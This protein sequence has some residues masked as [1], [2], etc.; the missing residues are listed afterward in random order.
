MNGPATLGVALQL[1]VA[2]ASFGSDPSY[3][4]PQP[5]LVFCN[6]CANVKITDLSLLSAITHC[7]SIRGLRSGFYEEQ[8]AARLKGEEN[9][10][11]PRIRVL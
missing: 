7:P 9:F 2:S 4:G 3:A 8:Q 5:S 11:K 1:P 10:S 6:P